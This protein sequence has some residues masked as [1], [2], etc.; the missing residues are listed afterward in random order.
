MVLWLRRH[1][2]QRLTCPFYTLQ[3]PSQ[4][5]DRFAEPTQAVQRIRVLCSQHALPYRQRVGCQVCSLLM[6][7][8]LKELDTDAA[9]AAYHIKALHPEHTLPRLPGF[10]ACSIMMLT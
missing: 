9:Y 2:S 8:Q 10:Y 7:P 6:L 3:M 4:L 1:C 5:Q